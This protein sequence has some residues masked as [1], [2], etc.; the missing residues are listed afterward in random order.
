MPIVNFYSSKDSVK[1][2]RMLALDIC[3]LLIIIS[4]LWALSLATLDVLA[5][6]EFGDQVVINLN[7]HLTMLCALS[8]CLLR[9][10]SRYCVLLFLAL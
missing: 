1:Q 6:Y 2:S 8:E 9:Y 7:H 3:V 5:P 10:S 4:G